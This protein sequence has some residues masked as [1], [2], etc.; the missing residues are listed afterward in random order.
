MPQ[1]DDQ[2]SPEC[3]RC[4]YD[5]SGSIA[6]WPEDRCPMQSRC[7]ECGLDVAWAE[8]LGR[9]AGAKVLFELAR[10][11]RLQAWRR[12]SLLC[13]RPNQLWSA[14][15]MHQAVSFSR[16][17]AIVFTLVPLLWIV[18]VLPL[19][20][21]HWRL[22]ASWGAGPDPLRLVCPWYDAAGRTRLMIPLPPIALG[23]GLFLLMPLTFCL[24]PQTL[25]RERVLPRHVGRIG[26]YSLVGVPIV[27]IGPISAWFLLAAGIDSALGR[28]WLGAAFGGYFEV[29]PAL[30][31]VT[32]A[33]ALAWLACFW[34]AA[35]SQYLRLHRPALVVG[36]LMFTASFLLIT[37]LVLAVPYDYATRAF[38]AQFFA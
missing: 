18:I 31:C 6:A 21:N 17:L 30:A 5:L 16:L 3:P 37:L 26:L 22:F 7:S 29:R 8:L 28:S 14:V 32:G 1:T 27:L 38:F 20:I 23:V 9:D 12:T 25:R 15:K 13:L 33:I 36:V 35:V 10:S 2:R 19:S 34:H 4:G 11:H 24:L